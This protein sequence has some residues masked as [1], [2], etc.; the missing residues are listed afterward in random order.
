MCWFR[1]AVG[2]GSDDDDDVGN[3][4]DRRT[5]MKLSYPGI[6]SRHGRL[7]DDEPSERTYVSD[8]K[9]WKIIKAERQ[10][11][12]FM[13]SQKQRHDKQSSSETNYVLDT[14]LFGYGSSTAADELSAFSHLPAHVKCHKHYATIAL[15]A[16]RDLGSLSA[17][18]RFAYFY[19]F[20]KNG[21]C[22]SVKIGRLPDGSG[23][24]SLGN[25][26]FKDKYG[27]VRDEHGSF[28]PP[29]VGPLFAP[30]ALLRVLPPKPE[31]VVDDI[32]GKPQLYLLYM[33]CSS[34]TG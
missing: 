4:Q 3:R 2:D 26:K 14:E 21:F 11:R 32:N 9:Q 18:E 7:Y 17:V 16:E 23:L 15:K 12:R 5:S 24:K 22:E 34:F 13:Q 19:A 8:K 30:P 31:L 29:D 25:G 6:T 28:W 20:T 27:I 1:Y 10:L 33:L